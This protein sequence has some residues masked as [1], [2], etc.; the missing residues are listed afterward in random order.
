M[1]PELQLNC[2]RPV[3]PLVTAEEVEEDVEED[4]VDAEAV[5][6][7]LFSGE[8]IVADVD[9]WKLAGLRKVYVEHANLSF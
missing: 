5:G 3:A 6:D 1:A 9:L 4:V 8:L 2:A 7:K